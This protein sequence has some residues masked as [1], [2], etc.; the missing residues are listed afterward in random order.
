MGLMP[1]KFPMEVI[2]MFIYENYFIIV[3]PIHHLS[4]VVVEKGYV[5]AGHI[6]RYSALSLQESIF[7]YC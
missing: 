2:S 1:C 4:I 7:E 3:Y 6:M 5:C